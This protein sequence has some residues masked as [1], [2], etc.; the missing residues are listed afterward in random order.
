MCALVQTLQQQ[1]I[2]CRTN[3]RSNIIV[4]VC[5]IYYCTG[6]AVSQQ[7]PKKS[8]PSTKKNDLRYWVVDHGRKN[9]KCS[10]KLRSHYRKERTNVHVCD[11]LFNH[12]VLVCWRTLVRSLQS[13]Q[14]RQSLCA[15]RN[16]SLHSG[17]F[18]ATPVR[19]LPSVLY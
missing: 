8:S 19:S 3:S 11:R 10:R 14:Y 16:K 18:Y 1:Y 5:T 4:R 9:S 12:F 6:S 17:L 13:V 2:S 15:N 7:Y